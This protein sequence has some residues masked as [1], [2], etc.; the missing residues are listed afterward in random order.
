MK[1]AIGIIGCGLI[2]ETHASALAEL[3][4]P[5]LLFYDIDTTRATRLA[6]QF[7][8]RAVTTI[9]AIIN[10]DEVSALY[11]CTHHDTH[12]PLAVQAA[13]RG[14]HL[15][16]E[17]PLALTEAEARRTAEAIERAGVICM[18]G[19]KLRFYP[20]VKRALELIPTPTLITATI[21]DKRW[22]DDSWANDPVKGGGN[23]L[24]QG[25][26]GVDLVCELA[27]SKPVRVFAEGGNFHHPKLGIT[28][29]L[30]LTLSFLSGAVASITIADAGESPV[31]GKFSFQVMDGES[32]LH[33][34][35][36][37]KQLEFLKGEESITVE[38]LDEFG[39]VEENRAFL[40]ALA[41][42]AHPRSD[43]YAGLR[44][45][46]IIERAIES[47]RTHQPR[48]LEDLR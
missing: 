25:C 47:A 22:P 17:K 23:V 6:E 43:H 34:F 16:I 20:T 11:L 19:F 41:T 9:E 12:G 29:S 35:D 45:T 14:K 48:S 30:V 31:T 4:S 36:R 7:G 38:D 10:S 37:L 21:L 46:A 2:G 42:G 8:G 27:R 40:D 32:S 13:A 39:F 28:D 15:F 24:S 44:A 1:N 18:C 26:H 33:L 3:G 5:A